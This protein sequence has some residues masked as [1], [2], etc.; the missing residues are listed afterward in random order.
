[1]AKALYGHVGVQDPHLISEV[2]T[3]RRRVK[4]LEAEIVR[5]HAENDALSAV[6]IDDLLGFEPAH[7]VDVTRSSPVLA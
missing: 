5:L 6:H 3:L 1:M 4:D 7:E 2:A